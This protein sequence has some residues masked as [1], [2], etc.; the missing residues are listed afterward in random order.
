MDEKWCISPLMGKVAIHPSAAV[1]ELLRRRREELGL[2]LRD[3]EARSAAAG[4]RVHFATLARVEQGKAEP[5]TRRLWRLFKLYDLPIQ[6]A[7][8]LLELEESADGEAL[9]GSF[10]ELGREG[11]QHW[12]AGNLR[13]AL[14]HFFAVRA[15]VPANDAERVNRQRALLGMAVVAGSLGRMSLSRYIVEGLLFEPPDPSIVVAT[16]VQASKCWQWLGSADGALGFIARAEAQL[17]ASQ[18]RERAWVFHQKASILAECGDA[19]AASV[20]VKSAVESYRRARDAHG[21]AA[22]LGIQVRVLVVRQ[23]WKA[24]LRAARAGKAV[25]RQHGFERLCASR[26]LDEARALRELSRA[27]E[28]LVVL[29]EVLAWAIQKDDRVVR[30]YAHHALWKTYDALGDDL[31]AR[32]E[33]RAA[34]D[35]VRFVDAVTPETRE[36]RSPRSESAAVSEPRE[37][38]SKRRRAS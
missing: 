28:A 18:H 34:E 31:R 6:L 16:L 24:A 1:A 27:E 4:E 37:K 36:V 3:V 10:E 2:S 38:R 29:K 26:G 15:K 5:G 14:A 13:K 20:A 8:D 21:E 9:T 12:K 33:F 30:F 23:E 11:A 7:A 32:A 19:A 17:E 25:A 22:A 35:H